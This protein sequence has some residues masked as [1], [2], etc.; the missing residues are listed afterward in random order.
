MFIIRV[1]N[2]LLSCQVATPTFVLQLPVFVQQSGGPV[3]AVVL[4]LTIPRG[5]VGEVFLGVLKG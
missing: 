2:A 4:D 3:K 1:T 5:G